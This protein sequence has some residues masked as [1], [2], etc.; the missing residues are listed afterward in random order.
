MITTDN[1]SRH[2]EKTTVGSIQLLPFRKNEL[3]VGW[4]FTNGDK[5]SLTSVQGKALNSLSISFKTDWGI[6][7]INNTINLPNLFHSD[8]RGVF[9]RSVDGISRQVGHIQDDAIRNINGVINN[10][11]DGRGGSNVISSGAFKTTKAIKGHQNGTSGY[12]QV[13]ELT[14]DASFTVPTA[15]ENRPLNMGM[16]PAIYLGI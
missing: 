6:K 11:S 14:F 3:P 9:L 4:Y 12:T 15:E 2:I 5:Y 8:G 10:V 1:I 7:V 13:S 16:T